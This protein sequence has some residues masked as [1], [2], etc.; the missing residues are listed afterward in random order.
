MIKKLRVLLSF[1]LIAFYFAA[2]YI[3][4]LAL[5]EKR[6]FFDDTVS[7]TMR[8][9]SYALLVG[10]YPLLQSI[11]APLVGKRLDKQCSKISVLRNIHL[12]NCICYL[13]LAIAA[14]KKNF[15]IALCGLCIPGVV[16]CAAPVGKS[17][18]ATLSDPNERTKQFASLAFIK[19]AVKLSA[20]LLGVLIFQ[21]ALGES[22]YAPL[23][24]LSSALSFCCFLYSFSLNSLKVAPS[25]E[26]SFSCP[27]FAF[28]G[29]IVRNNTPL[30]LVFVCL[31][32][33]YLV[34]VKYIPYVI[35]DKLSDS[36]SLVN[37][38]SSIVGLAY[39]LN[40]FVV[41]RMTEQIE[42]KKLLISILLFASTSLFC[43]SSIGPVWFLTLF[44]SLFCFTVLATC[45]EAGLSLQPI[46][47][48][49]GR[50]Q[51]VLYSIENWSY[52]LAPF[53]GSG[54]ATLKISYPLYFVVA[55][56]CL[57][58]LLLKYAM[59]NRKASMDSSL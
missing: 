53:I 10:F 27:T 20:P 19:G 16:G 47:G 39:C 15:Y 31:L 3:I 37:Y 42:R 58:A 11:V 41:V 5:D 28:F 44:S 14:Y 59:R 43:L 25:Q 26:A 52:L 46:A 33:G 21:K 23:F 22:G 1:E 35:F 36:P 45:V 57:A 55:V 38:F 51:G 50:V 54:L 7:Q 17:L 2:P 6:G 30:L 40:Q 24:L 56:T 32:S 13:M 49:Q 4:L 12:A 18:I 9:W 34:F 8:L 48:A 29:S